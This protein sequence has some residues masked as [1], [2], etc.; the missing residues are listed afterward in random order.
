MFA[1]RGSIGTAFLILALAAPAFADPPATAPAPDLSEPRKALAAYLDASRNI[2][3]KALQACILVTDHA[4]ANAVNIDLTYNLWLNY[5][6]R[7]CVAKFGPEEGLKVVGR[8]RCNEDQM[9]LDVKRAAAANL[10]LDPADPTKKATL[11]LRPE[12]NPIPGWRPKETYYLA[13]DGKDWKIDYLKTY[14]FD[15][16]ENEEN[17][18][19]SL[20]VYPKLS[21]AYQKLCQRVKNGDFKSADEAK[22]AFDKA[23]EDSYTPTTQPGDPPDKN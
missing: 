17:R 21:L 9:A 2:N 13:R 22:M 11:Y 1:L 18:K 3:F 7:A 10:D 14:G 23:I 20:G 8:L 6:E 5:F 12:R 19:I 15:N 4:Q 16:A